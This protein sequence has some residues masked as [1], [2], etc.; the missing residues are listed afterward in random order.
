MAGKKSGTS[1]RFKLEKEN[2]CNEELEKQIQVEMIKAQDQSMME[3]SENIV[4]EK[5]IGDEVEK[6]EDEIKM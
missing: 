4:E 1:K 6:I 5:E 3:R 2:Y